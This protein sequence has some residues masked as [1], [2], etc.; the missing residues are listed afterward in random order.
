MLALVANRAGKM[1]TLGADNYPRAEAHDALILYLAGDRTE[2]EKGHR[3]AVRCRR[4]GVVMNKGSFNNSIY[5]MIAVASV[6]TWQG[7]PLCKVVLVFPI[8]HNEFNPEVQL[9]VM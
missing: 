3:K 7:S 6:S 2:D 5:V 1:L 9:N 8:Y 4:L